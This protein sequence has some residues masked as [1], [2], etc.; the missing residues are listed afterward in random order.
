MGGHAT[1]DEREARATFPAELFSHWGRLDPIGM[2]ESWLMER[3][4]AAAELEEIEVRAIATVDAAAL[5][6][7]ADRD[8]LPAPASALEGVYAD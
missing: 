4:F 1:H 2:Y 7:L 3:G 6:A 5:E 8:R